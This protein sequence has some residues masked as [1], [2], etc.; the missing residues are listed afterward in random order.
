[1]V[2]QTNPALSTVPAQCP[3]CGGKTI[4]KTDRT[5]LA[6]RTFTCANCKSVLTTVITPRILLAVPVLLAML[7]VLYSTE[8]LRRGGV[9]PGVLLVAIQGGGSRLRFCACDANGNSR[10][11]VS[12]GQ[13]VGDP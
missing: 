7:A 8:L 5:S 3:I 4:H 1:M 13:V 2:N 9:L 6:P 10:S 12:A 11:S